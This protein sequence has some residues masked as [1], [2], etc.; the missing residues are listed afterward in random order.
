MSR[1]TFDFYLRDLTLCIL[2][3]IYNL[4]R[5]IKYIIVN[6]L[7]Y[8]VEK[9]YF[10]EIKR[11]NPYKIFGEKSNYYDLFNNEFVGFFF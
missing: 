3:L 6:L 11:K 10:I 2:T 4:Y 9:F 1:F 7:Y 5:D 8:N